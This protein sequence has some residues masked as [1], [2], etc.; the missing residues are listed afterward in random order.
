[1]SKLFPNYSMDQKAFKILLWG[2]LERENDHSLSLHSIKSSMETY[3]FPKTSSETF[4]KYLKKDGLL[5]YKLEK[6]KVSIEFR[7]NTCK[8]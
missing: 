5:E 6:Y 1:M 7:Y 4:V 2:V 8:L 3:N